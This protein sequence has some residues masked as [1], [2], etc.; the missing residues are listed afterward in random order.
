MAVLPIIKLGHPLL[1]KAADP[2]PPEEILTEEFQRFVDDLIETMRAHDGLGLAANQVAVPRQVAVIESRANPRYP[3]APEIPL[4]VF[5]NPVF[6]FLSE[7]KV[8]GW[9]VCLSVDKLRGLVPRSARA[10]VEAQDRRGKP[11]RIDASGFLA[12]VLQHELDH[13]Q[14]KVFLDRMEDLTTLAHQKEFEEFWLQ[15]QAM[16]G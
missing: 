16:V 4:Q 13:L 11:F 6:A 9:E 12:V 5:I 1:R 10:T 3:R 14:G 2:V 15:P 7:E 8:C